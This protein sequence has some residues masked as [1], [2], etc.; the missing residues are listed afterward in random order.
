MSQTPSRMRLITFFAALCLFLAAVE[1]AVPKPLPF[2]R[3]GLANVPILLSLE[4]MR[5]RDTLLLVV[6]KV[7]GQ[8]IISGTLFSYVFVFSA[9]GSCASALAMLLLYAV[10]KK[11]L[12]AVGLS[13]AGALANNLAQLA[14]ARWLLFGAHI[15]YIAP[16][17]LITGLVTGLALGICTERFKQ[18][19][20]WFALL[21]TNA[22]GVL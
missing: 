1:Y 13:L 9:A 14:V 22:G 10:G 8:G 17:L 2:L 4:K 15:R 5:R 18:K 3:L 19:S 12:S 11:Y 20:R 21:P 6:F 7:L 16:V